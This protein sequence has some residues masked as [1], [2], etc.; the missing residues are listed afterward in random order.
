MNLPALTQDGGATMSSLDIAEITG[1]EH[2]NVLADIRRILEDA[3]IKGA[4]FL[5]PF[6]MASGQVASVYNLPRREC[7]LVVSGY[8]VKYRLAI[9]DRW[10]K[11]EAGQALAI[12]THSEA[13]RLA[14]DAIDKADALA[15]EVADLKPKAQFH[16]A[17]MASDDVTQLAVACQVLEFPFGRNTLF[18]R[19]RNKGVLISGGERHNLPK[20]RYIEQG[21]FTVKESSYL[22]EDKQVHVRFT[23]YATQK[24][25]DW[26]MRE[27]QTKQLETA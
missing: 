2:K 11:L 3:E 16:D 26:L 27:F 25:L 10:H 12:P 22:D 20:Q 18:Q 9:I 17:V 4:E 24:G 13:L 8:S 14:A 15:L 6:K 5:A 21:L 19:L 7:D 1:K 23:T